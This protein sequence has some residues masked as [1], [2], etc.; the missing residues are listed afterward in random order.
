VAREPVTVLGWDIGGVNTKL[1]C[2][3]EG[4]L[5]SVHSRA[6]EIQ[7]HPAS[8]SAL[9]RAMVGECGATGEVRHAVTMTAELSQAFRTKRDGVG[10]VLDAVESACA[11]WPVS[12]YAV[13]G[14]FLTPGEARTDPLAVAAANW[15]AT[16]RV[17][18][19]HHPT[20]ILLDM[21]TTTTD[22]VP[23]RDGRVDARGWNDPDRLACGELVYT[24]VVRT[25]VEA[26]AIAVPYGHGM[27][28]VSAEAFALAGDVYVWLGE[29]EPR[30][31]TAR[32][33][34]RRP[35]TR[36]FCGERLARAIC[37]DRG[38]I[39]EDGLTRIARA[40]AASQERRIA[41]AIGHLR[42][43]RPA[44][45][46]AVVTGLG[47]F[48][49]SRAAA[50]AGLDVVS[51]ADSMGVAAARCAPAAA[52]ALLLG[53]D[54]GTSSR[55]GAVPV[56]HGHRPAHAP[57]TGAAA[58]D[59]DPS[60]RS[61]DPDPRPGPVSVVDLVVKVGG[62]LLAQPACLGPVLQRVADAARVSRLLIVPGGGPFADAVRVADAAVGLSDG[63]AHWMAIL[64]MDQ[65]AHLLADRMAGAVVVWTLDEVCAAL[66]AG[67]TPVLAPSRWMQDDDPL[68]HTWDV[69]SDSIA[70]W[71]AGR[72]G[73]A[74]L[75]LVK[76]AGA[77]GAA[78][79]DASFSRVLPPGVSAVCVAG[80]DLEGLRDACAG[81][82]QRDDTDAHQR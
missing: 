52:V 57:A 54:A 45:R 47:A 18:A 58:T 62:G 3:R 46:T 9:M 50:A 30:D 78:L 40:F 64:A 16:A 55:L 22:I 10:V 17:V 61:S 66:G 5:T 7:W 75:V 79:V 11:P 42:E 24:G 14:R 33:P 48:V 13:D 68:P 44:V 29:L 4:Q 73:A 41:E 28:G 8:L 70:A 15:A 21:G 63:A 59:V 53:D 31:Y 82:G 76:P 1:A 20:A 77:T 49:A 35:A 39:D 26:M 81:G 80:D 60:L 34:D 67:Q 12:V 25:P 37:A 36:L 74:R 27:A 71:V 65:Y 32:T 6:F 2:V 19:A 38:L 56:S 23:L 69:T 51:L 43:D 72:A